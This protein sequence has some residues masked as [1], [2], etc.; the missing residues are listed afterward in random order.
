MIF[1]GGSFSTCSSVACPKNSKQGDTNGLANRR[2]FLARYR[3]DNVPATFAMGVHNPRLIFSAFEWVS[4]V[5]SF[6]SQQT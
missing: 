3:L 6:T 2:L 5:S 1:G 4:I